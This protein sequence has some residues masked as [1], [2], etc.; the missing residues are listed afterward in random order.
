MVA[1]QNTDP[2]VCQT[3]PHPSAMARKELGA[4]RGR[5]VAPRAHL[6]AA[7]AEQTA[8]DRASCEHAGV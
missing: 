5:C 2:E 6:A 7:L 4:R 1:A 3:G 8:Q